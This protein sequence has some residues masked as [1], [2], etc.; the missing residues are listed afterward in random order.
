MFK[1]QK[2]KDNK[3]EKEKSIEPTPNKV[4]KIET[5]QLRDDRDKILLFKLNVEKAE[6]EEINLED[7]FFF[8]DMLE[9]S[10]IFLFLQPKHYK[11]SLW[12]GKDTSVRDRFVGANRAGSVTSLFSR[13]MKIITI[14]E[15]E[16]SMDFKILIG[17][18]EPLEVE[19]PNQGPLYKNLDSK[20]ENE[21]LEDMTYAEII[22]ILRR[23]AIPKDFQ[24]DFVLVKGKLFKIIERED[25]ESDSDV[26]YTV[27]PLK[28]ITPNGTFELFKLR[29]RI[30]L[31][32]NEVILTEFFS[33]K[34]DGQESKLHDFFKVE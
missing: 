14:E 10:S 21:I 31:H 13:T 23:L 24:R 12:Q 17:V 30:L 18:E 26:V 29:P 4:D 2:K 16:E 1:N 25:G 34:E 28:E 3:K 5:E 33:L 22:K 9:S 11:A 32:E 8:F 27:I 7:D 19:D 15:E 20:K 6:Y